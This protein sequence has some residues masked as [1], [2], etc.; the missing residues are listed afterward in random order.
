[1]HNKNANVACVTQKKRQGCVYCDGRTCHNE[2]YGLYL[3]QIC[4]DLYRDTSHGIKM[5][6]G[7]INCMFRQRYH[8]LSEFHQFEEDGV[9]DLV[10]VDGKKRA[11]PECVKNGY[12][13][14]LHN[15]MKNGN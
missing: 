2:R 12:Y 8:I 3:Y 6:C 4:I 1:M 14:M 11:L 9:L 13:T 15:V 7:M 10:K 5:E